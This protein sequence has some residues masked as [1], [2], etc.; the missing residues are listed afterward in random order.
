MGTGLIPPISNGYWTI[1][2]IGMG[3][4][5]IPYLER[6]LDHFPIWNGYWTTSL[7]GMG[8]GPLTLL[9]WISDDLQVVPSHNRCT[10]GPGW[11]LWEC[12]LLR[13]SYLGNDT[14]SQDV[15]RNSNDESDVQTTVCYTNH[16]QLNVTHTT[17]Y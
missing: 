16:K 9:E 8:T 12:W 17:K 15:Y 3:S 11:C 6:V 7:F 14:F 5:L 4:G 2:L 13:G 10:Q 1:H